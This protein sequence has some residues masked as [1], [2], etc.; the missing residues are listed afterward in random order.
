[1][2]YTKPYHLLEKSAINLICLLLPTS[3]WLIIMIG[4]GG[5]LLPSTFQPIDSPNFSFMGGVGN[6]DVRNISARSDTEHS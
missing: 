3:D 2:V 5:L 6:V 1:M 4:P